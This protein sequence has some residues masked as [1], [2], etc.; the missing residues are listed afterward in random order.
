[1]DAT[2]EQWKFLRILSLRSGVD[3][4]LLAKHYRTLN[5]IYGGK[6]KQLMLPSSEVEMIV[7][8][9]RLL[10]QGQDPIPAFIESPHVK[11]PSK[12]VL[13]VNIRGEL[14]D[15]VERLLDVEGVTS[16]QLVK[17]GDL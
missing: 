1:M 5:G 17:G 4:R 2:D 8:A 15:V 7:N 10:E 11:T 13:L 14:E 16:C 6:I 12:L 9:I 3:V